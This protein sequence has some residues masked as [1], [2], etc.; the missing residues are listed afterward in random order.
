MVSSGCFL[1]VIN[2]FTGCVWEI[3]R[4]DFDRI[5]IRKMWF[6]ASDLAI[7]FTRMNTRVATLT[8]SK[9]T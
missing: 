5:K 2:C 7:I 4:S 8:N 6:Y 9:K 1:F 3:G